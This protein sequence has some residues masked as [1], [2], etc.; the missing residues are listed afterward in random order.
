MYQAETI[1]VC[2]DIAHGAMD[3]PRAVHDAH[4][5]IL[6]ENKFLMAHSILKWCQTLWN[7]V[8][9]HFADYDNKDS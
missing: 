4:M 6:Q 7:P 5:R 1:E 8:S 2:H 9:S 3:A